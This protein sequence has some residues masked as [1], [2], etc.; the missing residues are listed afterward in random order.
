MTTDTT[1]SL[2][3]QGR[4]PSVCGNCWATWR[5]RKPRPAAIFCHHKDS[6]ARQ[7]PGG[8][9]QVLEHVGESDLAELRAK[10]LL[11]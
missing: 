10:G 11:L 5:A 2:F 8:D 6:A 1:A 3:D 9:W 7:R 4:P